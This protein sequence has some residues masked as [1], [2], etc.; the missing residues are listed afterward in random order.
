V[1]PTAALVGVEGA[2]QVRG[3]TAV[4]GYLTGQCAVTSVLVGAWGEVVNLRQSGTW[5]TPRFWKAQ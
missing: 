5:P 2:A 3:G 4:V 1:S